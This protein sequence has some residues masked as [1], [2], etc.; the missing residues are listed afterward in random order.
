MTGRRVTVFKV[1]N[2]IVI[3]EPRD[4]LVSQIESMKWIIASELECSYDEIDVETIDLPLDLSE[5]DVTTTGMFNWKDTQGKILTGVTLNLIEGSD[6]Y[7]DALN[8][9]ELE[10]HIIFV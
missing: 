10:D 1:N 9:G 8:K 6:E 2:E 3:E 4:L 5:I 7:L